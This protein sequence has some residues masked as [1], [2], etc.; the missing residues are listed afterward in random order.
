MLGS[1]W[2]GVRFGRAP[3]VFWGTQVE[4]QKIN[5]AFPE[6]DKIPDLARSLAT[7]PRLKEFLT[8]A[9]QVRSSKLRGRPR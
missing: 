1:L 5:E 9:T 7:S 3:A 2:A 8:P 4:V 6:P